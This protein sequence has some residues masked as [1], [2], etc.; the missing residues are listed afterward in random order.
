MSRIYTSDELSEYDGVKREEIYISVRG[1]IYDVTPGRDFYGPGQCI[2]ATVGCCFLVSVP[3]HDFLENNL[4]K[5][6]VQGEATTSLQE[7]SVA[8]P[9]QRCL[10][11]WEIARENWL[12]STTS[13]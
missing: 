9:L 1:K 6:S 3:Y 13:S 11:R 8:G 10:F 4:T 2:L 7:K 5:M 12:I